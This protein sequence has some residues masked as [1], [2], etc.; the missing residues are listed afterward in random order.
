[1]KITKTL[2]LLARPTRFELV[3]LGL[4]M[5]GIVVTNSTELSRFV[6]LQ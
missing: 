5:R 4:E 6:T 2:N 1:V 3:T